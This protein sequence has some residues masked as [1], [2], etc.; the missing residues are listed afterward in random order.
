M[1]ST[2][3][4]ATEIQSEKS[5]LGLS[6][7]LPYIDGSLCSY[8]EASDWYERFPAYKEGLDWIRQFI[9]KPN[10]QLHRPGAVCPF[11]APAM[12]ANLM[13]LVAVDTKTE[14]A[15]EAREKCLFLTDLFY[16]EFP[17]V[18]QQPSAT[19]LAFF[20]NLNADHAKE[21][22]DQGH[23]LLRLDFIRRGLM[24]GEFHKKSTVG[25]VGSPQ[26]MVMQSPV[27]MFA[28]RT[29][30]KHDLMFIDRPIYPLSERRE[31][32]DLFMQ[33]LGPTLTPP[34]RAEAERRIRAL[35]E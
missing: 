18:E 9:A 2:E 23:A 35:K 10:E 33:Y 27:P 4:S 31:C 25:S 28:V 15:L 21:F 5:G 22:I 19:L 12:Q 20:P 32:L 24:L 8:A 3:F 13:K 1:S 30:S 14:S 26:F 11:A 16:Q 34:V 7:H 6:G 17:R 29:L